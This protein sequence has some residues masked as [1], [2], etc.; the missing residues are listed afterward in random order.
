MRENMKLYVWDDV[1]CDWT[2]GIMFAIASSLSE[3][4]KII[5]EES[6]ETLGR[7]LREDLKQKPKVYPLTK[8]V[9]RVVWG[10]S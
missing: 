3:A 5:I 2:S 4:K 6:G 1:L 9:A 7:T 10:G 8:P